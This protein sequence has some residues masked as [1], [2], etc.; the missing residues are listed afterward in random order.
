MI[1]TCGLLCVLCIPQCMITYNPCVHISLLC[2][3][4]IV[5]SCGLVFC[6]QRSNDAAFC[7]HG[8]DIRFGM[9]VPELSING[10]VVTGTTDS[11]AEFDNF[12]IQHT[13]LNI[14]AWHPGS[15]QLKAQFKP[16]GLVKI[17]C[18]NFPREDVVIERVD[19]RECLCQCAV[20]L[21]IASN[22]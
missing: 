4:V 15:Y 18:D 6:G 8:R 16:S 19:N 5:P 2:L 17:C 22:L 12:I 3:C 21:P 13:S 9:P 10:S 20:V 1:M 14:S 7:I 11:V